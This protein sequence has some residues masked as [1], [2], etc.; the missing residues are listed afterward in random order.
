[1]PL[2]NGYKGW[3]DGPVAHSDNISSK[4]FAGA[5]VAALLLQRF[6]PADLPWLHLDLYA[7]NEQTQPGR[8][9][10][11]EAQAVRA[12]FGALGEHPTAAG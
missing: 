6:V 11:R 3:L 9:E 8:P 2:W 7:W 5:I 12:L 10:G 1:M 4:P